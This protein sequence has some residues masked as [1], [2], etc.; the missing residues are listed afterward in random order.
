MRWIVARNMLMA[1]AL[2]CSFAG[3]ASAQSGAG[4]KAAAEALFQEG[5]DLLDKGEYEQ[6]CNKFAASQELDAGIGTLLYLAECFEKAGKT[7]SAWA[8][9]KEA[10][11]AA[12]AQG[13]MDRES[14]A[15]SRAQE[16]EA[17]LVKIRVKAAPE[18]M[19]LKGLEVHLNGVPV[20]KASWG[21]A[22]PVDPGPQKVEV[23]APGYESW[24]RTLDITPAPGETLL[25][26]PTLKPAAQEAT[27]TSSPPA[28]SVG[29][30]EKGADPGSDGS[31]QRTLG[32]VGAGLGVVVMGAGGYFGLVAKSKNEDSKQ[33]C[34]LENR[35][36]PT[37]LTL[38]NDALDAASSSTIAFIAGG[39]LVATGLTLALTAPSAS[40]SA[41]AE[42]APVKRLE[43]SAVWLGR[44]GAVSLKGQF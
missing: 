2:A 22:V 44:D 8:T 39:V 17:K 13:Q 4:D 1:T 12:R 3:V 36:T 10:A 33:H 15:R 21:T 41:S 24:S 27:D 34:P 14:L 35:C 28:G 6:A 7:A 5:K 30:S 31:G 37:G 11:G 20:P 25:E 32:L 38:R 9:F 23:M 16:L 19:S 40:S 43:L 29:A 42:A 18:L 26:I